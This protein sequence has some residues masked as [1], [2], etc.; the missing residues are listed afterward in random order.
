MEEELFPADGK[1]LEGLWQ[2]EE[3]EKYPALCEYDE[4]PSDL[5]N[6]LRDKSYIRRFESEL[7][8]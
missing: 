7:L 6:W 5:W 1:G 4:L 3:A 8:V 2:E